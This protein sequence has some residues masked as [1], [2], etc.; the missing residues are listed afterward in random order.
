MK[1]TTEMKTKTRIRSAILLGVS[2][3][4][5][6]SV[7]NGYANTDSDGDGIS[8]TLDLLPNVASGLAI[9]LSETNEK[10]THSADFSADY[11][12]L[13]FI[14]AEV[15]GSHG[16]VKIF[17]D[18]H[19]EYVANEAFD[20]MN[21]NTEKEE[22]FTFTSEE[23]SKFQ[24]LV[25]IVGTN[26]PAIISKMHYN[27][28]A[29]LADQAEQ[30]SGYMRVIDRDANEASFI[31][32][33][34]SV[35]T[36]GKFSINTQGVWSY[37]SDSSHH[38]LAVG[39]S[40]TDS[41]IVQT[42]DGT[43]RDI[44]ITIQGSKNPDATVADGI[45]HYVVPE[46]GQLVLRDEITADGPYFTEF[47]GWNRNSAT[48]QKIFK[49]DA[50]AR[51]SFRM[52]GISLKD[53]RLQILGPIDEKIT[54]S[55]ASQ[56]ALG[57]VTVNEHTGSWVYTANDDVTTNDSAGFGVAVSTG[58]TVVIPTDASLSI[59]E[60][61]SGGDNKAAYFSIRL[62]G[63]EISFFGS[64]NGTNTGKGYYF[65]SGDAYVEVD[66]MPIIL[67][68]DLAPGSAPT[69]NYSYYGD[70]FV[71]SIES[72][73]SS[74]SAQVVDAIN[75]EPSGMF[76][77]ANLNVKRVEN[78]NL[79]STRMNKKKAGGIFGRWIAGNDDGDYMGDDSQL[80][81]S[82]KTTGY[83]VL[84]CIGDAGGN[85]FGV[86]TF[87][88]IAEKVA[89]DAFGG[90]RSSLLNVEE[91][92]DLVQPISISGETLAANQVDAETTNFDI[93]S[94]SEL[95]NFKGTL[96]HDGDVD[97]I[98]INFSESDF[99]YW[100]SFEVGGD[101]YDPEIKLLN[102]E[103]NELGGG[104]ADGGTG[105]NGVASHRPQTAGVYYLAISSDAPTYWGQGDPVGTG[106]YVV[107][108]TRGD[109]GIYGH[110]LTSAGGPA[111]YG[112]LP[113]ADVPSGTANSVI[114]DLTDKITGEIEIDGD[115]DWY[116]YTLEQGKIYR[117]TVN[118]ITLKKPSIKLRN[119]GGELVNGNGEAVN[120]E[121][122]PNIVQDLVTIN[123]SDGTPRTR[124][125]I[126]FVAGY[127]GDYFV[128]ILSNQDVDPNNANTAT[129]TFNLEAV[130]HT[131]D[132]GGSITYP[133]IPNMDDGGSGFFS[134]YIP[135]SYDFSEAG[136]LQ[137]G[138]RV[139]GDFYS[140][141]DADFF[142]V[143]L[144]N[145][146]SYS[147]SI[148]STTPYTE[149][150][151]YAQITLFD[152]AGE[153]VDKGLSFPGSSNGVNTSFDNVTPPKDGYY[154]IRAS[155]TNDYSEQKGY[156]IWSSF[157]GDD[158]SSNRQTNG[159]LT[160]QKFVTGEIEA[161]GDE[162]WIRVDLEAGQRYEFK[163]ESAP[164]GGWIKLKGSVQNG[165][166]YIQRALKN[167]GT[168]ENAY[169]ADIGETPATALKLGSFDGDNLTGTGGLIHYGD[170]DWLAVDLEEGHVYQ[171]YVAGVPT[172]INPAMSDPKFSIYDPEGQLIQAA[173][174]N[175]NESHAHDG[176][177]GKDA[178]LLYTATRTGTFYIGIE[179]E[180]TIP[181][182]EIIAAA[183][184][185]D[186]ATSITVKPLGQFLTGGTVLTFDNGARF[187]IADEAQVTN[188]VLTGEL[189]G[190]IS[191]GEA[192]FDSSVSV[193][194]TAISG[195]ATLF[196][197][198]IP[199][200]MFANEVVVFEG[201]ATFK[202][203]QDANADSTQLTG[204]L[205]G[206]VGA[207][208]VG[209]QYRTSRYSASVVRLPTDLVSQHYNGILQAT[210]VKIDWTPRY[211]APYFINVGTHWGDK[212]EYKISMTKLDS[213]ATSDTI[214]ETRDT[215]V[216]LTLGVQTTAT[217]EYGGDRDW[218]KVELIPGET[219][220]FDLT[221]DGV[222]DFER[223]KPIIKVFDALGKPKGELW[224]WIYTSKWGKP[225]G[226]W[227]EAQSS[228]YEWSVPMDRFDY[229]IGYPAPSAKVYYL[230]A[231][232][233]TAGNMVFT[234]THL[235]DDQSEGMTTTGVIEV[236]GT[237]SGTWEKGVEDGA[238]EELLWGTHGGDG[239]WFKTDLVAGNTY[240]IDL[241]THR[242]NKPGIKLYTEAGVYFRDNWKHP[243][244]DHDQSV[245]LE[246][247]KK[248]HAQMTF[249]ANRTG[250]F[251]INA[252]NR[253]SW[254]TEKGG[255]GNNIYDLSL[256]HIPDDIKS[257]IETSA[258]LP[259]DG[260]V[261]ATLNAVNDRDWFKVSLKKGAVYRFNLEGN[262]LKDPSLRIR[263][264]HGKQLLYNDHV[265]GWWNPTITYTANDDGVYY[266]DVAGIDSGSYT[267]K[268]KNVFTP[269]E[270]EDSFVGSEVEVP[271]S[272]A[273]EFLNNAQAHT[274]G[275]IV[276][277]EIE[278]QGDRRWY[279]IDLKQTR[280]YE[281]HQFGDSLQS[282]SLFLRD[283]NGVPVFP[284]PKRDKSRSTGEKLVLTYECPE[285]DVYY[286]DAGGF[287]ASGYQQNG[288][289]AGVP[290]GSFSIQTFDHGVAS[291]RAL[292]WDT[293]FADAKGTA[294]D[295]LVG[296]QETTSQIANASKRD[297]YKISLL[298]G[299]TY[300]FRI[301]G[302]LING[303]VDRGVKSRLFLHDNDGEYIKG[304]TMGDLDYE[305]PKTETY[306]IAVGATTGQ[307][308]GNLFRENGVT[309]EYKLKLIQKRA[310]KTEPSVN[311]FAELNVISNDILS[312]AVSDQS[313]K[314]LDRAEL[315]AILNSVKAG[316]ITEG[317]L[318]D[319]RILVANYKE[320]GL[321]N[322]LVTILDNLANG[323]PANQ[324]YTGREDNNMGR[325]SRQ[326]MGNLYPGSSEDRVEKLISKWFM[327]TDSPAQP[328]MY[329]RLDLPLFFPAP[330][331]AKNIQVEGGTISA[332]SSGNLVIDLDLDAKAGD[333]FVGETQGEW[334][335]VT[336]DVASGTGITVPVNNTGSVDITNDS[337][338]TLKG[339]RASDVNQGKLGDCYLLS[340]LSAV[341]ESNIASI[342]GTQASVFQG[343]MFVD[344]GDGTFGVRWYDNSG[345]ERWVT[346]D[347]YVPGYRSEK[348]DNV[349]TTS[350]E[351][352]TMLAEKAYVQLNESDNIGQDG[353]NRYG[354]GN[355]FGIA[356]GSAHMAL[357]HV[358]GQESSY[359][360][361]SSGAGD[362]GLT[363]AELIEMINKKLPMVFSTSAPCQLASHY[364]VKRKHTYTYESYDVAT[365]KFF[366]RNPWGNS[367][368]TVTFAGLQHMGSNLAYLDG[369]RRKMERINPSD[370]VFSVSDAASSPGGDDGGASLTE[371]ESVGGVKLFRDSQS[372]IY[373]GANSGSSLPVMINGEFMA[374]I[375]NGRSAIAAESVN[376]VNKVLWKNDNSGA[377]E[378]MNFNS[379]W[380][381]VSSGT[382]ADVAS[383]GYY[384]YETAF[385]IDANNDS[386][387]GD[388]NGNSNGD[389][390][391]PVIT[392]IGDATVSVNVGATYSDAGATASDNVDGTITSSISA[393]STVDTTTAGTYTVTYNVSDTAGNAADAVVRTVNVVV[394]T[395]T[396]TLS[397]KA[398]WNLVSFYVEASDMAPA[399]VLSPISAKLSQIKNL[400]ESYD[401]ANQSFLN[402]LAGLNTRD[403]YWLKVT[404]DVSL[405]VAGTVPNSSSISVKTGWNL[406]GYPMAIGAAPADEL[407]SLGATVAQ[408]KNLTESY[409]PDNPA[410]LNTL[411]SMTPGLGYW[412]KV[413]ADG[414][415]S[416]G[417]AG[418][419]GGNRDI[420]KAQPAPLGQEDS[421]TGW[422]RVVVYPNLGATVFARVTLQGKPAPAGSLVGAFV[423]GELRGEYPVVISDGESFVSLNVN[424][425]KTE[426]V[427][428][429]VWNALGQA[430]H[431]VSGAMK[432]ELGE[433][434][435]KDDLVK[436]N[437]GS[438]VSK[439]LRLVQ[440]GRDQFSFSFAT[441]EGLRYVVE[442]TEDFETWQPEETFRGE[443]KT[444]KFTAKPEPLAAT[445]F[446]RIR[447]EQE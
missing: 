131:D 260:Q 22:I 235:L 115:R 352:W 414:T 98:K 383:S 396:Q 111:P 259:V 204:L 373:A 344:N 447:E 404:E 441:K 61:N 345:L 367:H 416:L 67:K 412:L 208:E 339:A 290:T 281:F 197:N 423:G 31:A 47:D 427:T 381:F 142:G 406:V 238:N 278:L 55:V 137:A 205:S 437:A 342:D 274:I 203:S 413:D 75:N 318:T 173:N 172:N 148:F 319:L 69:A 270:G 108:V 291:E 157:F 190:S 419:H 202:L 227:S 369:T 252:W 85:D 350:G 387:I 177:D 378:E 10:L 195:A 244:G 40:V 181:K 126:V 370:N 21:A 324:Y 393:N 403:G 166:L 224:E 214:G 199:R 248:G 185:A 388:P 93:I 57:T 119:S 77:G 207:D 292:S 30:A 254:D 170:K 357:S 46:T 418:S 399:T 25:K 52:Q 445:R 246:L 435:G 184:A 101:V 343:D 261:S 8:D 99:D 362:S 253:H 328:R 29:T 284:L 376:G 390:T 187:I 305:A 219:Y 389:T 66:Y 81:I 105:L 443:G 27:I 432:L 12:N 372:Q 133:R 5:S 277:D 144:L 428:Y 257:S 237:A 3:I 41:F 88:L 194:D 272:V 314:I 102:S 145:R 407:T 54:Y 79:T 168:S 176:I 247:I 103:L 209:Y 6:A 211:T 76:F 271:T 82:P 114:S 140:V 394:P 83:Y 354:I 182:G 13:T 424:L 302:G 279:K 90:D 231:S 110:W 193:T 56:P 141:G 159:L 363:E 178:A 183:A 128:E 100:Y 401:P 213:L 89:A 245:F 223:Q 268:C 92:G 153:L 425:G 283:K 240:K 251:F 250:V 232:S 109:V 266:V 395:V 371:V 147:F 308:T 74:T 154:Y 298:K 262:S 161:N 106:E 51:Y 255:S 50:G 409:D 28:D 201:G 156:T 337:K 112:A 149:G 1:K 162:D 37:L 87:E 26:D 124:A 442:S 218:Y 53:S 171:I 192:A 104:E 125:T 263:D 264:S 312:A 20:S 321:S 408:I 210:E 415:W 167:N 267:M 309:Y 196:V 86:G 107:T 397:L 71:I 329:T 34:D 60:R 421:I 179:A 301:E 73:G 374:V 38:T 360:F 132:F 189:T 44:K 353:T 80:L 286:L 186:G 365:Q 426:S 163:L 269:P 331:V 134:N 411:T 11:P 366:L 304:M 152:S 303:Q 169:S 17:S 206:N 225:G 23:N 256:V 4:L 122:D 322:Y 431:R 282:P 429:R 392:L 127:T 165:N 117:W 62:Q 96:N 36:Y 155:T 310:P 191:E 306:Y 294:P 150:D 2:L 287:W 400:T 139:S 233:N 320:V 436:L 446:Y 296:A 70:G 297:L 33:T 226:A 382:S 405:Q 258:V 280:A 375:M 15:T 151:Q 323:D 368:A 95:K 135:E 7:Q 295:L 422:G 330:K 355:F 241:F 228:S 361:I 299:A 398:G 32:Q 78:I 221:G 335:E 48:V 19:Y 39:S 174:N 42:K 327:G 91:N 121:T 243:N 217:M 72:D 289:I 143:D 317:E 384:A 356:G 332:G 45:N 236:G 180:T 65:G 385:G 285:T 229:P 346:V 129:G 341:A 358:T 230:E 380:Q 49:L 242:F 138:R 164:Y 216:P 14:Q 334:V 438:G 120:D 273:T 417:Q 351:S 300:R 402:T 349:H 212:G 18:K 188:T 9:S 43:Q 276:Q 24:I 377:L 116:K 440:S 160:D 198:E 97:Y 313:D 410:F 68:T 16:K 113:S 249:T 146:N 340:S 325:T 293:T 239:D 200:K 439:S 158:F 58:Q 175:A 433:V 315:L 94:S 347:R 63:E 84:G 333:L 338:L 59:L 35:G 136:F 275:N 123:N 364:G 359:K 215:A 420:T 118:A 444:L 288:T 64:E 348:L 222:Q 434:Y 379:V 265:N 311:W 326:D 336:S 386:S 130:E 234:V 307:L 430:E 220:K 316:G 391:K